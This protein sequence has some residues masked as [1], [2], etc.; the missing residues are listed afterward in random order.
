[1][2]WEIKQPDGKGAFLS[3]IPLSKIPTDCNSSVL[4]KTQ[5]KD[6]RWFTLVKS[7]ENCCFLQQ[8]TTSYKRR[9]QDNV[10]AG[11]GTTEGQ[12]ERWQGGREQGRAVSGTNGWFWGGSS[13]GFLQVGA[14]QGGTW[15]TC[16]R[17][18][19]FF[20]YLSSSAT[21]AAG[22]PWWCRPV[23][24]SSPPWRQWQL[25]VSLLQIPKLLQ[26]MPWTV[27]HTRPW[28]EGC[29]VLSYAHRPH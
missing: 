29:C 9:L 23:T 8:E 7:K 19:C 1:M 13:S 26:V 16:G 10:W 22:H 12:K 17:S 5:V 20:S 18:W 4:L 11:A 15:V 3:I 21:Q 28:P 6:K 14:G 25:S 2:A 24:R 27:W